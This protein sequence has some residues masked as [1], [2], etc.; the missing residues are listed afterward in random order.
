[1]QEVFL[2][3][4]QFYAYPV[5]LGALFEDDTSSRDYFYSLPEE[6]QQALI[7][8]NIHTAQDLHECVQR[9]KLKE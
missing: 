5:A 4:N 1:M 8:E 2:L 6:T 3:N 9:F 7:R